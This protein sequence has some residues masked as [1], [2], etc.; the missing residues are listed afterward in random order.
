[1]E[2]ET[3]TLKR[4]REPSERAKLQ[5]ET[6]AKPKTSVKK[7]KIDK[8][9]VCDPAVNVASSPRVQAV[10]CN[11]KKGKASEVKM[12]VSEEVVN[13]SLGLAEIEASITRP[14]TAQ[15]LNATFPEV[16]LT[17]SPPEK[18]K[19]QANFVHNAQAMS[20]FCEAILNST[21]SSGPVQV[22][23]PSYSFD[24]S[25]IAKLKENFVVLSQGLLSAP[26][27][28]TPI[29]VD[30]SLNVEKTPTSMS[31][32]QFYNFLEVYFRA[33]FDFCSDSSI[34]LDTDVKVHLLNLCELDTNR[35]PELF[36]LLTQAKSWATNWIKVFVFGKNGSTKLQPWKCPDPS[37]CPVMYH[38]TA[39]GMHKSNHSMKSPPVGS[40]KVKLEGLR[41][42][43]L[44]RCASTRRSKTEAV[45]EEPVQALRKYFPQLCE[46]EFSRSH[47]S[48]G[49]CPLP[50]VVLPNVAVRSLSVASP[51]Q[52]A[53][54]STL[55]LIVQHT[56]RSEHKLPLSD[57]NDSVMLVLSQLGKM[58]TTTLN[59]SHASKLIKASSTWAA[60]VPTKENIYYGVS[61]LPK[62]DPGNKA[63]QILSAQL[64]QQCKQWTEL[65]LPVLPTVPSYP[66]PS[67]MAHAPTSIPGITPTSLST[68]PLI[69]PITAQAM[70]D[71]K[72]L[73][74]QGVITL[75]EWR[76]SINQMRPSSR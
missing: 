66:A 56:G 42:R 43:E 37:T 21:G 50:H 12:T 24:P 32:A 33:R 22:S 18:E 49:N 3:T 23:T 35:N 17:A 51:L 46:D 19:K 9:E 25:D 30:L 4:K 47:D 16:T 27:N 28:V 53:I 71:L 48:T 11:V 8:V 60:N 54:D 68:T 7:T 6:I 15:A 64:Q 52:D 57:L 39:F 76:N 69:D 2:T 65:R 61:L 20:V 5:A 38:R 14:A 67:S 41:I 44:K 36:T 29:Q 70:Q 75:E 73:L 63:H 74:K 31:C 13:P 55:K 10:A 59:K 40:M 26:V 45:I 72:E 1:M 62:I 34:S 58:N